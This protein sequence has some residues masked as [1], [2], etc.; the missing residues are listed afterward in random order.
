MSMRCWTHL[1]LSIHR[2]QAF[3]SNQSPHTHDHDQIPI[4]P[5]DLTGPLDGVVA[6]VRKMC[7]DVIP[8]LGTVS[9]MQVKVAKCSRNINKGKVLTLDS[10]RSQKRFSGLDITGR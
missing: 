5:V 9:I 2:Q 8:P 1:R 4:N 10:K 7:D 6:K 3:Q